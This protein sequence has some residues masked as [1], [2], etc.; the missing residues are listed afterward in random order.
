MAALQASFWVA[1]Y[2]RN[3][4]EG[5]KGERGAST[6][7]RGS[8]KR[9]DGGV[10]AADFMV[11]PPRMKMTA[12]VQK[13]SAKIKIIVENDGRMCY[14]AYLPMI[15]FLSGCVRYFIVRPRHHACPGLGLS[16]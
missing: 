14:M 13:N 9:V 6:R 8:R 3:D 15:N 10:C 16:R 12:A 2:S 7:F 4:E 1:L 11:L 5:E